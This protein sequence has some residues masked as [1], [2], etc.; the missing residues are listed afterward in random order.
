MAIQLNTNI[1]LKSNIP[2][3]K[4]LVFDTERSMNSENKLGLYEGLLSYVKETKKFFVLK[5]VDGSL[6]WSELSIDGNL[7]FVLNKWVALEQHNINEYYVFSN[8]LYKCLETNSDGLFENSKYELYVGNASE[9]DDTNV[10]IDKTYSS[11]KVTSLMKNTLTKD[12]YA[13]DTNEGSVKYADELTSVRNKQPL[14]Y[15]GTNKNN[16]LGLHYFPINIDK[17]N[18]GIEQ[19]VILDV[20]ANEN[21]IIDSAIDIS[22]NKVVV[23]SYKFAA[24][25][26]NIQTDKVFNNAESTNFFYNTENIEF[27]DSMHIKK[28]YNYT[29]SLN[30][31]NRYESEVI[32]STGFL[33]ILGLEIK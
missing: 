2:L 22:D 29:M 27:T 9:I 28:V 17:T 1:N 15:Y 4:R 8:K 31:D 25:Q 10:S 26:Q 7:Q 23:D 30:A 6:Q 12:V 16:E 33:E 32:D 21:I 11:S 20:K 19:K 5:E 13:S 24:G 18:T 14:Q 3:D